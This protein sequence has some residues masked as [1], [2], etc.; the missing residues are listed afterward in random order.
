[1]KY[2]ANAKINIRLN[3]LGKNENDYHNLSMIN[4]KISLADEIEITIGSEN[5]VN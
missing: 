2:L 5:K 3:V 4:A 1:M